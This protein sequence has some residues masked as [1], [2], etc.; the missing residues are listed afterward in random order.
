MTCSQPARPSQRP[1][2]HSMQSVHR[3][4]G[5]WWLPAWQPLERQG[6]AQLR[7]IDAGHVRSPNRSC[8][9]RARN[10]SQH[11]QCYAAMCQ[12]G[13]RSPSRGP[14]GLSTRRC[15]DETGWAGL[16]RPLS[17]ASPWRLER[18]SVGRH[19]RSSMLLR[20][21]HQGASIFFFEVD[22]QARSAGATEPRASSRVWLFFGPETRGLSTSQLGWF[23]ESN[24]LRLPMRPESRSLNLS[25]SVAVAVYEVWRQLSFVG[26]PT[27]EA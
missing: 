23:L 26:A 16:P 17:S 24:R 27:Q 10:T 13:C 15:Q 7:S 21:E 12:H 8:P 18:L 14:D 5:P 9:G 22:F 4:W 19:A 6:P 11:G 20:P 1:G 2:R 25:N 3:S